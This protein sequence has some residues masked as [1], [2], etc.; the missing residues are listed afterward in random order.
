MTT[1]SAVPVVDLGPGWTQV[2]QNV[3][4]NHVQQV[5][6]RQS[7]RVT[8]MLERAV[9]GVFREAFPSG[10]HDLRLAVDPVPDPDGLF[11]LLS[12]FAQQFSTLDPECRRLIYAAPEGDLASIATAER[13]GFRYVVD[14]EVVTGSYSLMVVEPAWVTAVD[15]DLDR[16][17]QT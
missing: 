13:A 9:T 17:P 16:V 4:P 7:T 3:T 6:E 15:M 14:V 1:S 5:V 12:S 8:V 2:E 11:D 10:E